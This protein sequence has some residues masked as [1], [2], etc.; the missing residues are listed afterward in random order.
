MQQWAIRKKCGQVFE[1]S[2][3]SHFLT[4]G[5]LRTNAWINLNSVNKLWLPRR[6]LRPKFVELTELSINSSIVLPSKPIGSKISGCAYYFEL[7]L[8]IIIFLPNQSAE[9]VCLFKISPDSV[10]DPR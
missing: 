4:V 2:E 5:F 7:L 6:K 3:A 8:P 10:E 1:T 9:G